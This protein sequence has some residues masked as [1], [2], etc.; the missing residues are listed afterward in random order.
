MVSSRCKSNCPTRDGP[1]R[2]NSRNQDVNLAG[3]IAPDL[4]ASGRVVCCGIGR[5]IEL[6][7]HESAWSLGHELISLCDGL[8]HALQLP[9]K[10]VYNGRSGLREDV[11]RTKLQAPPLLSTRNP[12]PKPTPSLPPL[13]GC[14]KPR[15]HHLP[16]GQHQLRP[17]GTQ[18]DSALNAHG[19]WHG[20]DETVALGSSQKG[21]GSASVPAGWLN[22]AGK[23]GG[24]EVVETW[25]VL[26]KPRWRGPKCSSS[27]Y[28]PRPHQHSPVR[29][30]QALL[31]C[32]FNHGQRNPIFDTA[33]VHPKQGGASK[34]RLKQ[35]DE[36]RRE[37]RREREACK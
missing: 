21:E 5:V 13:G 27:H 15:T 22:L 37:G 23:E 9:R 16:G 29:V 18:Q 25:S 2:A 35:Q 24:K 3:R 31:F 26:L 7:Q 36:R 10:T 19:V 33:R 14:T 30:D 11:P 1:A 4:G 20:E 17:E 8:L 32:V 6:R 28:P 12:H 34:S